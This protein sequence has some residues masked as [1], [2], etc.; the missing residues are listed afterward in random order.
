MKHK[1]GL[2]LNYLRP[3]QHILPKRPGYIKYFDTKKDLFWTIY[4]VGKYSA[5]PP[6]RFG[7]HTMRNTQIE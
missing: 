5:C 4:N 2:T 7:V 6:L 1:Y 3:F